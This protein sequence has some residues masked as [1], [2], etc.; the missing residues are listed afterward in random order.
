MQT[1]TNQ[2][3]YDTA[4]A[5]GKRDA[6]QGKACAKPFGDTARAG[7]SDGYHDGLV[8]LLAQLTE[9]P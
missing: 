8:E 7:Y 2:L 4:Y 3:R 6:V 5:Q 9:Q 1:D